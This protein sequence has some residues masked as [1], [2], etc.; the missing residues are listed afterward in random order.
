MDVTEVS[1]S[2]GLSDATNF[3]VSDRY[4]ECDGYMPL[5]DGYM[6][7]MTFLT[8]NKTDNNGYE[9]DKAEN[10]DGVVIPICFLPVG[11]HH[12]Y[13]GY[14]VMMSSTQQCVASPWDVLCFNAI[15]HLLFPGEERT[16]EEY[17]DFLQV[18]SAGHRAS[19]PSGPVLHEL[20]VVY[21]KLRLFTVSTKQ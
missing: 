19:T 6:T 21:G 8:E 20:Y 13:S 4:E 12:R 15:F 7:V 11:V 9:A 18:G 10:I 16:R 5:Y 3:R 17:N 2:N 14:H 1:H